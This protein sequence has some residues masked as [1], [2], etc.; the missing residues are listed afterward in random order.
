MKAVVFAYHDMGCAGIQSL[1]D[2]GYDI[3]AIFTHPDNPGENHFFGSVARLA[4]EH[5]IPVWAPED[6]NHPLWIER[7][8]EMKPDVLFSFYY[9]NL[10]GDEILS[11][12]PKGAF[13]LHGSLLPKYRGRAPLNWVLVNGESETGVTLHRMVNRA[14]AGDIVAQQTV[15][16]GPDDAALTL[17]RK[18]CAAA[19]ELLSQ[20]LPAILAGTT[21]ER[22]QDHSQATYV[23]RR[24]PEDGR[25]DWEQPAQTLHNLVRAVSDPW[26]GAFGYAG[27]NKFIVWK[28]RV[29]HDLPAAKPGTVLSIAPLIVACQD[30][31]LEI[32][33][34]QTERGVYMQGAQLAQALGLVSG[35]VISSKPVVAIKRRT[36]VLI[37]GGLVGAFM[38]LVARPLTVFTCLLPFRKFTTKARLYVSWVGLRGAVPILFAIYPLMAHVEN[39]GLLFNVVFLGT[40]ISLLVQ[41]TT[42][43]GMAN[44][45]GLA[46]EERESAFSVDMHQDMKSALTEVE[47]NETMLESG[48]TLKDITLPENTLVMMVCRDGEYF[49]PQGKTELKLGDK[50]LVISDRS[51]ELATT[52]KDMG[53]DD[54]MKLG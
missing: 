39:A 30:G 26:P 11:L 33:T 24:T 38:I 13:N 16:I 6:V 54:V 27:A 47:V 43:S 25:L 12:A 15:A 3:A 36:R 5:G 50:L 14:D 49:V 18:L 46:Y 1:L 42:V 29:R 2:A 41:G 7:I 40:I 23:G 52:Y 21:D 37:L 32:V 44:L 48:H 17:H 22:P 10:L 19:T 34:G 9:R 45:L 8:R 4:A 28:S 51:E 31:A 35:A 53:I 20:A